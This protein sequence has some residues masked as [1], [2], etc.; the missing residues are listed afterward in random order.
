MI[1]DLISFIM[2]ICFNPDYYLRHDGKRVILSATPEAKEIKGKPNWVSRIHPLYAMILAILSTP[3]EMLE[4][5]DDIVSFFGFTEDEASRILETLIKKESYK[6]ALFDG[7]IN[8]FPGDV[9]ALEDEIQGYTP[10]NPSQFLFTEVDLDSHRMFVAPNSILLIINNTCATQCEYCYADKQHVCGSIL[11]FDK[12]KDIVMEA[13]AYGIREFEVIGGEFFLFPQ[14]HEL[15]EFML[16]NGMMPRLISTKLPL[17]RSQIERFSKFNIR[18]QISLD[19][20][21]SGLLAETLKI[22][23]PYVEKMEESIRIIDESGIRYQLATVVTRKTATVDNIDRLFQFIKTLKS[24]R[25]WEIRYAF[26]SLYSLRDYSELRVPDGFHELVVDWHSSAQN[27]TSCRILIPSSERDELFYAEGGSMSFKGARCSANIS[28]MVILPDGKVTVCEQLYWNPHYI[29][30]DVNENSIG[31]IW[32]SDASM[33]LLPK[34]RREISKQSECSKC[35]LYEKCFS[36]TNRC[37][38]NILKHCGMDCHDYP[39]PRCTRA[40]YASA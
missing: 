13:K 33:R 18:L 37:H 10:Y 17:T 39:D 27:Q 31:E 35:G 11:S 30:G 24:L 22:K 3:K 19:S 8:Y 28:N 5:K 20:L 12:I 9:I 32:N 34:P 14:W 6:E 36:Y 38:A 2:K 21:D 40:A 26:K 29:V 23:P 7:T 4:A 25:S 16:A 1:S 15:L